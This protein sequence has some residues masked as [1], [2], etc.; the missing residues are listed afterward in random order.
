MRI[1][2][3]ELDNF[4]SFGKKTVIPFENGFT[5][6]SG[7]NGSGKSNV[8]D[9]LM[10]A[11][12]LTTT[13]NMRAERLTDLLNNLTGRKDCHVK[14]T[15]IDEETDTETSVLRRIRV[16][17]NGYDSKYFLNDEPC[18]LSHVHNELGKKNISPHGFNVVM[19][20]DVSSIISMN[21]TE[22]RK[23]I[24]EI[25][26][27][28]E[29][30]R[31]I[32][33]AD[34]E[35][36]VVQ[37]R[38]E[39]QEL[40]LSEI[41]ERLEK[42]QKER[43]QAIK[44]SELRER[45]DELERQFLAVRVRQVEKNKNLTEKELQDSIELKTDLQIEN[46]NINEEMD[47]LQ[48]KLESLNKQIT[49]LGEGRQKELM[50][51]T[52]ERKEALTRELSALEYLQKQIT[53]QVEHQEKLAKE[54]KEIKKALKDSDFREAEFKEEIETVKKNIEEEEARYQ[55]IQDKIRKKS[56]S[57]NLS[58]K[59]VLEA[60]EKTQILKDQK[61]TIEQEKV[62]YEEQI[63]RLHQDLEKNRLEAER[64]LNR[65]NE[66]REEIGG[67]DAN[68]LD[69]IKEQ[70]GFQ[71]NTIQSLKAEQ[72]DTQ[73][74][75]GKQQ[76][77][78]S[79][80]QK[81]LNNLEGQEQA[82]SDAGYGRAVEMVLNNDGVHGT[83]A[84]LGSV[85]SDYQLA[86]ETAAGARL[87]G[88]VVDD[89]Y[90]ASDC[91]KF[92]RDK[93]AGRATFLPLNK[94]AAARDFPLP[95]E[96]GVIGWAID[97]V[98]F[99]ESYR[100]AFAYAFANTLVVK[101]LQSGRKMI[102]RFRMVTLQGDLLER[103]G[104]MTGGSAIK[105][106]IHFGT[107][108]ENNKVKLEKQIE[109]IT[110]Y[111]K[112]LQEEYNNLENQIE[113]A[114]QK[115]TKLKD[116][117]NSS[118]S[119]LSKGGVQIESLEEAYDREKSDLALA[120][121][122]MRKVEES[123]EAV[124]DKIYAKQKVIETEE[125]KLQEL[126]AEMK[127]SGLEALITESQD[128]EIEVKRYQTMLNNLINESKS[129]EAEK[130]FS[131][132]NID[133]INTQIEES[134]MEVEELNKK[135]PE[136]D[137]KIQVIRE[138]VEKLDAEYAEI[139]K[140]LAGFNQER[141]DINSKLMQLG[142]RKG[143]IASKIESTA[144]KIV[145]TKKK[146]EEIKVHYDQLM[147]E[148][149]EHPEL[150]DM[151]I[152]EENLNKLQAELNRVEK[153]MRSMEPINMRAVE[154]Y[155]EVSGREKDIIEKLE[156]LAKE[157]AMIEEKIGS[158]TD[159]KKSTFLAS[160]NQ[161][162]EYFQEIFAD[163]S[164]GNGQLILEDPEDIFK[165]GLVIK[166]QPRGKKMQRLESMSGGEKSLTALSFL[167]AL[168]QCNPAPFYAFD[169]VDSALDGINVERIANKVNKNAHSTQFV[170]VSHRRPMLEKSDRAIGVSVG[171]D[172]FSKVIGIQN[173]EKEERE[174]A[175]AAA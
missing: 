45:R 31:K 172:G 47:T 108:W 11:L 61:A 115:I 36:D 163:L 30:D 101:D 105:S 143:E 142:E 132:Q 3:L 28:A 119:K 51:I 145:E 166:A 139:Q 120:S 160:Y 118:E 167:F 93:K 82:A 99:D 83:L 150:K 169:E 56:A 97:L 130:N 19:Q 39:S 174:E 74:E 72:K 125:S 147:A 173:I 1:K 137:E 60:Q 29:F 69:A 4:K 48:K 136:H 71:E 164:F 81:E 133:R 103:S 134:R 107:N 43:D 113:E 10:F 16:K 168:Q 65:L 63:T 25:A 12:G 21:P 76:A 32:E 52:E 62:R 2:E 7:P 20:G 157:K 80:V 44:Y 128:V 91:I 151:V 46:N 158:F 23:I 77:K 34:K 50:T 68:Q 14:V 41:K 22:R 53:D 106:N 122:E 175:V 121:E 152:E 75:I 131:G 96:K 88:V 170:V 59:A 149:E 138:E 100:D 54:I 146:L 89:D 58:S 141:D 148:L 117:L 153:K 87:R 109:Q 126:A 104:A 27:V 92:L 90:V 40:I 79:A 57:S 110:G 124:N 171:R 111:I 162:D 26:G 112:D 33:L 94:L 70:I 5:A 37:E 159:D 78:L 55:A 129:I 18:T 84:Q 165:G 15:F 85:D 64:I 144:I 95:Q 42:L 35:L 140:S 66:V 38:I 98:H 86:L 161:I 13:R 8:V 6:I 102:G 114:R 9:S 49:E 116:K 67:A 24:D 135:Q 127:D 73:D 155:E 154:E 123:L 17:A 156:S